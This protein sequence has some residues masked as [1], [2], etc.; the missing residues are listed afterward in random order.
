VGKKKKTI[1]TIFARQPTLI[2]VGQSTLVHFDRPM[3][4]QINSFNHLY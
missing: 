3:R 1:Q 4:W 2:M